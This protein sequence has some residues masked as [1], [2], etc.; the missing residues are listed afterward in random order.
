MLYTL[1]QQLLTLLRLKIVENMIYKLKMT[2]FRITFKGFK[3]KII[4]KFSNMGK[5]WLKLF[6]MLPNY[7]TSFK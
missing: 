1:Q 3:L 4:F 6:S 2:Q 5:E 7:K